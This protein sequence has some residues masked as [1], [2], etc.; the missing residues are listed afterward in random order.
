MSYIK[1]FIHAVW[2]TKDRN[3]YLMPSIRHQVIEHIC[4]NAKLKNIAIDQIN[5]F[6]D[7]LH[8]LI[9]MSSDQNIATIMNLIKGESSFWINRQKLTKNKF[10]WQDEYFAVSVGQSQL[11]TIRQYISKQETHHKKKTFQQE[12]DEFLKHYMFEEKG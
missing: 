12:Y 3:P 4:E 9:S 2:A 6:N 8:C 11:D 1:L 5:G 7:H 10:G